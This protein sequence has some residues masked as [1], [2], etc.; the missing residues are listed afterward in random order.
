V[1]G[2]WTTGGGRGRR[3]AGAPGRPVSADE[4]KHGGVLRRGTPRQRRKRGGEAQRVGKEKRGGLAARRRMQEESVGA[5][6][7]QGARS[8]VAGRASVA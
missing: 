4:G 7:Q 8:A 3:V 6:G 5:G 1:P 2:R